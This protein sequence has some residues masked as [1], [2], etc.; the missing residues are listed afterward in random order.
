M[1]LPP[2]KLP[3][4]LISTLFATSGWAAV[5]KSDLATPESRHTAL[6]LA[7]NL[8]QTPKPAPISADLK[9]PFN[10]AGFDRPDSEEQKLLTQTLTAVQG[11]IAKIRTPREIL[12]AVAPRIQPEGTG[13]LRG[14]PILYFSKKPFRIGDKFTVSFEGTDYDLLLTAIGHDNFTLRYRNEETTRPLKTGKN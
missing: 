10:P 7:T 8:A 14:T 6:L 12:D 13:S 2:S 9:T 3:I 4:M 11:N 1:T 5:I